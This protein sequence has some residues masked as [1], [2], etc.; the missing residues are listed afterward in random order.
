MNDVRVLAEKSL[1]LVVQHF[2]IDNFNKEIFQAS[3]TDPFDLLVK[4]LAFV[5]NDL[6]DHD[7]GKLLNILYKIDVNEQ[8]VTKIISEESPENIGHEIA[9]LVVKREKQKV[10]TREKYRN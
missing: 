4:K 7:M 10:L 6:L 1:D 9:L 5:I 2:E 3:H 8:R